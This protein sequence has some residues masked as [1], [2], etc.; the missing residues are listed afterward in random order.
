M[1]RILVRNGE[2]GFMSSAEK[3]FI[4]CISEAKYLCSL[5]KM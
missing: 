1:A 5:E 3:F 4:M 2:V